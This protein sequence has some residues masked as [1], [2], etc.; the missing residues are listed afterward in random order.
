MNHRHGGAK[1]HFCDTEHRDAWF[2]ATGHYKAMSV[3]GHDARVVAVAESNV[4]HPRRKATHVRCAYCG[5]VI[6]QA[7]MN[8]R[9]GGAKRHF[10]NRE[11]RDLWQKQSGFYAAISAKGRAA[12]AAAVASSNAE[13]PRRKASRAVH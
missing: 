7:V 8:H 1:H 12:R 2:R 3:V 5:A 9:H 11:H 13:Q 4:A 6:P 10:C